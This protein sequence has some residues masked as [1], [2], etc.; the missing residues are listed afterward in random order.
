MA[1]KR[2][3]AKIYGVAHDARVRTGK[4]DHVLEVEIGNYRYP[5]HVGELFR[6]LKDGESVEHQGSKPADG[7]RKDEAA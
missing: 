1:K 5:L 4:N 7:D 2:P 6:M 3:F